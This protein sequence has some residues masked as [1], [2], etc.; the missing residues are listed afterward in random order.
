MNR[1]EEKMIQ[2]EGEMSRLGINCD[3]TLLH[4]ITKSLGPSIYKV[5][6]E[7]VSGSDER[8]LQTVKGNYL[9]KKLGLTDNPELDDAIAWVVST[10][11]KSNRNKY[12]AIFYYLL[13]K[14]LGQEAFYLN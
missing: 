9:I 8:E 10:M 5:D 2:Y 11:G 7:T 13:V 4:K 1:F 14:K 12:R 3:T 6:A